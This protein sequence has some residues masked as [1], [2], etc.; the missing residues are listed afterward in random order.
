MDLPTAVTINIGLAPR[1]PHDHDAYDDHAPA[2]YPRNAIEQAI[3]EAITPADHRDGRRHARPRRGDC[4]SPQ[5]PRFIGLLSDRAD[6]ERS[7][8]R[9]AARTASSDFGL[10]VIAEAGV[11]RTRL[12]GQRRLQLHAG[13]AVQTVAHGPEALID[14]EVADLDHRSLRPRIRDVGG[15]VPARHTRERV[16]DKLHWLG[17]PF[18]DA[19]LRADIIAAVEHL[20][21]IPIAQL[22]ELLGAVSPK[23]QH[24]RCRGRL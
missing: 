8:R 11:R 16:I 17:E 10:L 6:D 2:A 22:T 15:C 9:K 18:A 4:G 5:E 13:V 1:T 14:A 12:D 7:V 21:D 3:D 23:A 19:G 24:P 20:E